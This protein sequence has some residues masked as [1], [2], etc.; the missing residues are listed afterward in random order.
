MKNSKPILAILDNTTNEKFGALKGYFGA[1]IVEENLKFYYQNAKPQ[2]ISTSKILK[3]YT[4]KHKVL[5]VDVEVFETKNT[6]YEFIID[7]LDLFFNN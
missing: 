5:E 6:R 7:K 2:Y 1:L 4:I 3:R